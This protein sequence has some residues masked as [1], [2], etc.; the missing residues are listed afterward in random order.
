MRAPR[1][2]S[3]DFYLVWQKAFTGKHKIGDC[4]ESTKYVVVNPQCNL[5]RYTRKPWQKNR[6]MWVV[7]RNTLM[8]IAPPHQ[9]EGIQSGSEDSDYDTLP[10]D[11][12]LLTQGLSTTGPVMQSQTRAYQLAQTYRMH[13]LKQPNMSNGNRRG[14][15][16][17]GWQIADGPCHK[18]EYWPSIM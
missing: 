4:W 11:N 13:G 14:I 17:D 8:H 5:P 3:R 1:L 7:H 9:P 16:Q 10:G 15:L 18:S 2:K 12:G 6:G